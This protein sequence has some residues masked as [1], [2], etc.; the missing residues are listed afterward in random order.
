MFGKDE[1]KALTRLAVLSVGWPVGLD[2][3]YDG[4]IKEGVLSILGWVSVFSSIMFLAPCPSHSHGAES[5]S[6]VAST[7]PLIILPLCLGAYGAFLVIRKGFRLLRQ[8]ETAE[9]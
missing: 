3:F 6:K 7:D 5:V 9:G 2:R 8:F 4:K 1:K